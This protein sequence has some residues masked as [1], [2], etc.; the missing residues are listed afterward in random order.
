MEVETI[1]SRKIRKEI[2]VMV[3]EATP[4]IK[5]RIRRQAGRRK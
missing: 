1:P 3:G 4:E 2:K 5:E